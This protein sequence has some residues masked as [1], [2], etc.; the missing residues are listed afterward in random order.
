MVQSV[1]LLRGLVDDPDP[2]VATKA[3]TLLVQLQPDQAISV[4]QKAVSSDSA[5]R[6]QNAWKLLK[7]LP[8]EETAEIIAGGLE[9]LTSGNK[10]PPYAIE[11]LEAAESRPEPAVQDALAA[12]ESA[13]PADDPLAPWRVALRG[14][15][16]KQ[17]AAIFQSHPAGQ[18]LRCHSGSLEEASGG[19]AGPN[20]GGVGMRRTPEEILHSIIDPGATIVPGFGTITLRFTNG[21]SISGILQE[22]TETHLKFLVGTELWLIDQNDIQSRSS[23]VSAMPLMKDLLT[24]SE[25]RD[26][27]AWL[28]SLDEEAGEI[29]ALEAKR[30][31]PATIAPS[32]AL[33]VNDPPPDAGPAE[34]DPAV[35][36]LGKE[37]YTLCMACHGPTGKGSA[38]LAPPLA[39]SEWV[40]GPPEN[41]IRIQLR[42]LTGPIT[43]AGQEY[44]FAAPMAAQSFQSD[45]QIAAVLTYVR[46]RFGN[47]APAVTPSMVQALRG[48]VGMPAPPHGLRPH[49]PSRTRPARSPTLGI[50]HHRTH[51]PAACHPHGA[52]MA[53]VGHRTHRPLA[54]NLRHP[55][56][57]EAQVQTP[58]RTETQGAAQGAGH[59]EVHE[60]DRGTTQGT[61][62]GAF[63]RATEAT[64]PEAD[65]QSYQP[66]SKR[67][68]ELTHCI[69]LRTGGHLECAGQGSLR[70]PTALWIGG[71]R[72]AR[73][74]VCDAANPKR[75]QQ[76]V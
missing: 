64:R 47:E 51:R 50:S 62:P 37:S 25:I 6:K 58:R 57:Q 20:L 39:G 4:L 38:G 42:G 56:R 73:D 44:S 67:A 31:D 71:R 32:Q 14:G 60:E 10:Q 3:D 9:L 59:E 53:L 66:T 15:D 68:E 74:D 7:D 45:E 34:L 75:C 41:L 35:M 43:V 22:E 23:P 72:T 12:W 52:G 17:G 27:V 18:C 40:T 16:P 63:R 46:N 65:H 55:H 26:L 36:K 11:I 29:A 49:P 69:A 13:L 28:V 48:E 1:E 33:A 2:S 8:G 19:D 5:L 24:K 76:F 21:G 54:R 70:P 61:V 30:F